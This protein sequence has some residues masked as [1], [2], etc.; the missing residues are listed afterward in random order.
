MQLKRTL[1]GAAADEDMDPDPL[2]ADEAPQHDLI[3]CGDCH[4]SFALADIV[5][6]IAHKRSCYKGQQVPHVVS[7]DEVHHPED[8]EEKET[9]AA[10]ITTIDTTIHE[11]GPIV[12]TEKPKILTPFRRKSLHDQSC[13]VRPLAKE[14]QTE[15]LRDELAQEPLIC[16]TCKGSFYSAAELLRHVQVD[17]GLHIYQED[18]KE[19]AAEIEEPPMKEMMEDDE[20]LSKDSTVVE[21]S[22]RESNPEEGPEPPSE[23]GRDEGKSL[24]EPDAA[25]SQVSSSHPQ[26]PAHVPNSQQIPLISDSNP[27]PIY[28]RHPMMGEESYPPGGSSRYFP[29]S[30]SQPYHL[31]HF[32]NHPPPDGVP[33]MPSPYESSGPHVPFSSASSHASQIDESAANRLRLFADVAKPKPLGFPYQRPYRPS[34]PPKMKSCEFCGKP[35]KFQSNLIVH[36]RSHTGEKPYKCSLCDHACSQ[37]SKL[38]RHMKTHKNNKE[39]GEAAS[40]SSSNSN[41]TQN[42]KESTSNDSK[43]GDDDYASSGKNSS[44]NSSVDEEEEEEM[45]LEEEEMPPENAEEQTTSSREEPSNSQQPPNSILCD[46]IK[47]T[48]LGEIQQYKEAYRQA[49]AEQH[50]VVSPSHPYSHGLGSSVSSLLSGKNEVNGPLAAG[51]SRPTPRSS[52]SPGRHSTPLPSPVQKSLPLPPSLHS[53]PFDSS[54]PPLEPDRDCSK[55][56]KPEPTSPPSARTPPR[57]PIWTSLNLPPQNFFAPVLSM[58]SNMHPHHPSVLQSQVHHNGSLSILPG[59]HHRRFYPGAEPRPVAPSVLSSYHNP[60]HRNRGRGGITNRRSDECEFCGKVFKN[61]SN[62]TVHRRS[63]TGEKPYKCE[64]C[65][66]ACAQSSKLTR[67]MKTHGKGAKEVFKCEVCGMPFSVYSTLEKH[68]KKEHWGSIKGPAPRPETSVGGRGHSYK[69]LSK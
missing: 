42:G 43:V 9:L 47:K 4:T 33:G 69:P 3:Q 46:V 35:F 48:G 30:L 57:A 55:R 1:T 38:K 6:F 36:R 28:I 61:C 27:L 52:P 12:R 67:H 64:L 58:N 17:H 19:T 53:H 37:A 66:Y 20:E 5:K 59:N 49:V 31:E 45:E 16:S 15:H 62:L 32:P 13:E 23:S 26:E 25:E 63:H 68:M 51:S 41:K 8:E 22:P 29:V 34:F 18:P 11:N 65:S 54:P 56:F 7:S 40:S 21:S 14:T 50:Y 2:E 60:G 39:H 10:E 44:S 24:P